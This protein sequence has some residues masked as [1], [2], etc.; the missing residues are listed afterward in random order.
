MNRQALTLI[1]LIIVIAII[2]LL[3]SM[4]LAASATV[5]V[6]AEVSETRALLVK[7]NAA[8][9]QFED[10]YN[11]IP[12]ATWGH[13]VN[14]LEAPTDY[15]NNLFWRLGKEMKRQDRIDYEALLPTAIS[16]AENSV[17]LSDADAYKGGF[18]N[19]AYRTWIGQYQ[20]FTRDMIRVI[21]KEEAIIETKR[22]WQ[23]YEALSQ[24]EIGRNFLRKRD[25]GDPLRKRAAGDEDPCII[26]D[27]WGNP[28]IYVTQFSPALPFRNINWQAHVTY[29]YSTDPVG[30]EA[31]ARITISDLNTD[32]SIEDEAAVSDIRTHAFAGYEGSYEL[33]SA[34]P[35]ASFHAIR[36]ELVNEDNITVNEY[37]ND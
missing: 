36:G 12:K 31:G 34:G 19:N 3:S 10:R 20:N 7:V 22:N 27:S 37:R 23:T 9:H 8:I 2:G 29:S 21:K 26:V 15:T 1:E 4:V 30:K 32:G 33:W 18:Q 13:D 11:Y 14:N 17:S 35:D 16:D 25:V 24:G 28:L 5:I 6:T